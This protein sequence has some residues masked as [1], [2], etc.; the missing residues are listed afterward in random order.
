VK[1]NEVLLQCIRIQKLGPPMVA[2]GIG[3]VYTAG[4]DAWACY[5]DVAVP[6]TA[7][8]D[9]RRP[10]S[11]RTLANREKAYSYAVARTMADLFPAG[12]D[13]IRCA[14]DRA[15]L[16]PGRSVEVARLG[17][18]RRQHVLQGAARRSSS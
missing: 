2:R 18:G 9:F 13:M 5:D 8:A 7:M 6:T 12:R 10:A 1:W 14:D 11:E 16:R 4:F 3:L 17:A 15:G